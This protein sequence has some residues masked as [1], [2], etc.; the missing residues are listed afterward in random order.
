MSIV[1]FGRA[2]NIQVNGIN[3]RG[4]QLLTQDCGLTVA[5]VTA[6]SL[7]L[8]GIAD[9]MTPSLLI[10]SGFAEVRGDLVVE[11]EIE[12]QDIDALGNVAIGGDLI[13]EN[14]TANVGDVLT[15]N[16]TRWG[17]SP[18]SGGGGGGGGTTP[19]Y[20][21]IETDGASLT[22]TIANSF[23]S[24][25]D[26]EGTLTDPVVNPQIVLTRCCDGV[27]DSAGNFYAA[28]Q[29]SIGGLN[30]SDPH[31]NLDGSLASFEL[32][33]LDGS[34]TSNTYIIKYDPDGTA[35][36]YVSL[37][38]TSNP[39]STYLAIDSA[40]NLFAAIEISS[41]QVGDFTTTTTHGAAKDTLASAAGYLLKWNSAGVYQGGA[42]LDDLPLGVG[43]QVG[44]LAI[45]S[46][47]AIY[48]SFHYNSTTDAQLYD[49]SATPGSSPSASSTVIQSSSL[50]TGL[51]FVLVKWNS[52]GSIVGYGA[53]NSIN[54]GTGVNAGPVAI[55]S[56]DNVIWGVNSMNDGTPNFE[57]YDFQ[58]GMSLSSPSVT[59]TVG[60]RHG[61][62]FIIKFTSGGT[63]TWVAPVFYSEDN[64]PRNSLDDVAVGL[65]DEIYVVG[66]A[67][68][69]STA[70]TNPEIYEAIPAG[71][72][73]L[74][75]KFTIPTNSPAKEVCLAAQYS[76]AGVA[77]RWLLLDET[78]L[79]GVTI[80]TFNNVTIHPSTG[81]ILL[82]AF[83]KTTA[84]ITPSIYDFSTNTSGSPGSVALA[85]MVDG[86]GLFYLR[87]DSA[88]NFISWSMSSGF[89]SNF[90]DTRTN[91]MGFSPASGNPL[92][93]LA[94]R[95]AIGTSA[96]GVYDFETTATRPAEAYRIAYFGSIDSFFLKYETTGYTP[97]TPPFDGQQISITLPAG[98]SEP[99]EKQVF[100]AKA[101]PEYTLT[102]TNAM[103]TCIQTFVN[104]SVARTDAIQLIWNGT[105]WGLVDISQWLDPS[106]VMVYDI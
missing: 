99:L 58:S 8:S 103:G 86:G 9:G 13:Y 21:L 98:G 10:E 97:I 24:P 25:A 100:F 61:T 14:D 96:T 75:S 95:Q 63:L 38:N 89:S 28:Y 36:S 33:S 76:A 94:N 26:G 81:D 15:Y 29:G 77:T 16:G 82:S 19:G 101:G 31:Y 50:P 7:V 27:F 53:T 62:A 65:S 49:F 4:R 67:Y 60:T 66:R 104:V 85:P 92:F 71:M 2:G 48:V 80:Q 88:G 74:T 30:S 12:T 83:I 90:I 22:T 5:S 47:D 17:P 43:R 72:S 52:S 106:R 39:P 93:I 56:S 1:G 18:S 41:G 32:L 78:S 37:P 70:P 64:S 69:V 73:T 45:D 91:F 105:A 35:L 44:G 84:Q 79:S 87:Y 3:C 54:F 102:I 46:A 23:I 51:K 20:E 68:T 40:D 34:S 59:I 6:N 42:P 11:G 55:D 57:F